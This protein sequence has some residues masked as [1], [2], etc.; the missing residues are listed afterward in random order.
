MWWSMVV[1]RRAPLPPSG[2]PRAIAPP[3][4]LSFAGSA[5]ISASQASGT[6]AKASIPALPSADKRSSCSPSVRAELLAGLHYFWD[7]KVLRGLG[8]ILAGLSFIE[9]LMMSTL[10][11]FAQ[12][13]PHLNSRAY[14]LMFLAGAVGGLI[15]MVIQ[16]LAARR[17]GDRHVLLL[18]LAGFGMSS[19]VVAVTSSAILAAIA[20]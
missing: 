15:G 17:L 16:P 10:V 19:V 3:L 4:G 2:W 14:G 9:G 13:T 5:P 11:L 7:H 1:I 18:V 20:F 8:L 6:G 12:D